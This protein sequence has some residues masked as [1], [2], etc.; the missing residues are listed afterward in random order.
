VEK[1]KTLFESISEDIRNSAHTQ[2][3]LL[4]LEVGQACVARFSEDG[5]WYRGQVSSLGDSVSSA[6]EIWFVDFGNSE[7]VPRDNVRA[8]RPEWLRLPVL[9]YRGEI[10]GIEVADPACLD[11][12]TEYM[13]ELCNTVK[14]AEILS[15]NPLAVRLYG[16]DNRLA[17]QDLFDQRLLIHN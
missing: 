9:Q 11:I 13:A 4:N 15:V 3:V 7:S 10:G 12:V 16:D 6:V 1:T 8:I 14:I 2:P 5:E 17:Y